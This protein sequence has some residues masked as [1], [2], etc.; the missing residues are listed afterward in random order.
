M[1]FKE[2]LSYRDFGLDFA[3]VGAVTT[4]R[5]IQA[6]PDVVDRYLRASAEGVA[7]MMTHDEVT[8]RVLTQFTQ[9]DDPVMLDESIA[10]E[11]SRTAKDML[12]TP[13]GMRTAMEEL[14]SANPKAATANGEDYLVLEPVKRLNDSGFIAGLYR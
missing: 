11:H 4:R 10:F 12:P 14:A 2:L 7:L 8:R 5:Y 9:V 13:A 3:N 1:G 6:Q